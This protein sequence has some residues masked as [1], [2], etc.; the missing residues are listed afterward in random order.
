MHKWN[1]KKRAASLEEREVKLQQKAEKLQQKLE[2]TQHKNPEKLQKQLEK[3]QLKKEKA[4]EK[5]E[6]IQEKREMKLEKKAEKILE[7]REKKISEK[8]D[9]NA[10][11]KNVFADP[12][13]RKKLLQERKEKLQN[14]KKAQ[15][16][17]GWNPQCTHLY[18]DANNQL[19]CS[20]TTRQLVLKKKRSQAELI[21]VQAAKEFA[22]HQKLALCV[23]IFDFLTIAPFEVDLE[24]GKL[25]VG[26]AIPHFNTSD[27]ALVEMAKTAP[28]HSFFLDCW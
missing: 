15:D 13:K 10:N 28:E 6:K 21:L 12:E 17:T 16:T 5:K 22:I 2:S 25:I 9:P 4:Q 7:K 27:D 3:V 8:A 26:K 23:V 20:T 1:K 11:Q 24:F 19:F 18:I 14:S